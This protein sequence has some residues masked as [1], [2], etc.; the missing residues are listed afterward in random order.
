MG[1]WWVLV[2]AVY[3]ALTIGN[4]KPHDFARFP[5]PEQC[6]AARQS[7]EAKSRPGITWVAICEPREAQ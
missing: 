7:I 6:E 3:T 4:E 2:V 5:H 1:T